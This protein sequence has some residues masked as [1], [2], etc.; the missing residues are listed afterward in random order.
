[1]VNG[2]EPVGAVAL[3]VKDRVDLP[4]PTLVIS[5]EMPAG[6]PDVLSAIFGNVPPLVEVVT[7]IVDDPPCGR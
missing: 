6:N 5:E 4:P 7:V 1:M 2:N 3:A